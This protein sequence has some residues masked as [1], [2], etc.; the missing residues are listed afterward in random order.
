MS[1]GKDLASLFSLKNIRYEYFFAGI[2]YQNDK[3]LYEENVNGVKEYF[4]SIYESIDAF[5]EFPASF[6]Y[7]YAFEKDNNTKFIFIDISKESWIEKMNDI[8]PNV[9]HSPEYLF[10]EFF[11]NF[12]TDTG[13]S[14]MLDLTDDELAT[15]YD[16]H[17]SNINSYFAD[18]PNFIKVDYEDPDLI[19][20][21]NE[22]LS[23]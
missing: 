4:D 9:Q 19:N 12:Y 5:I 10:E 18:S 8:K 22:F 13:K 21:I 17:V 7:Q 11:C 16:L 20:K 23:I 3:G 15:I 1:K 6:I 2:N 14:N